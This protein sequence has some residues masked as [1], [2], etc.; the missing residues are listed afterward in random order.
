MGAKEGTEG[1]EVETLLRVQLS[2]PKQ[3]DY[4]AGSTLDIVKLSMEANYRDRE[5]LDGG[6]PEL[7]ISGDF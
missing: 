5:D 7:E 3:I 6:G 1:D 2:S 4:W